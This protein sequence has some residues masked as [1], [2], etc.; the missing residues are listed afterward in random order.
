MAKTLEERVQR[1]EDIA[2]IRKMF[3]AHAYLNASG[4]EFE[5]SFSHER[6]DVRFELE[7]LGI[8]D[9]QENV[10]RR[11]GGVPPAP[12]GAPP[13]ANP[14]GGPGGGNIHYQCSYVI[15][16][17]DDGQTAQATCLSPGHVTGRT[18][19]GLSPMWGYCRYGIDFVKENG[20]W[21]YW[22]QRIF[23]VFN[24]LYGKSWVQKSIDRSLHSAGA[25]ANDTIPRNADRNTGVDAP[26]ALNTPPRLIPH[27]PVPYATFNETMSYV[28]PPAPPGF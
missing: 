18:A 24:S 7:R 19:A 26:F 2:E 13:S 11:V 22:H 3:S 20:K 17:A 6:P 14:G 21:K 25:Q 10:R 1:L 4:A 5:H 16:V 9:G 28:P 23:T 27:L 12:A 15:E 8:S